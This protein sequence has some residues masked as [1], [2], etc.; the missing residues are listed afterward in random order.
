MFLGVGLVLAR[1]VEPG[2]ATPPLGSAMLQENG[3]D[4][5]LEGSLVGY[6]TLELA[7]G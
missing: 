5:L 1:L 6:L 3:D 7:N 4:L 2:N